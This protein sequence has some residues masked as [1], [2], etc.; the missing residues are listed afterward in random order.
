MINQ[1]KFWLFQKRYKRWRSKIKIRPVPFAEGN[2][3]PGMSYED[4]QI[5]RHRMQMLL[6]E[7]QARGLGGRRQ[8]INDYSI[9]GVLG[10]N[11]GFFL[12]NRRGN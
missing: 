12:G 3:I 9:L 5:R 1:I 6:G 2:V 8:P 11:L 10:S 7:L 4:Q